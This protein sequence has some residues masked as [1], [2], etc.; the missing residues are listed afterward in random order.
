MF[1]CCKKKKSKIIPKQKSNSYS[2]FLNICINDWEANNKNL[3]NAKVAPRPP[4]PISTIE[5]Y[6]NFKKKVLIK[7]NE[8]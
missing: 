5:S 6:V 8:K 1:T 7:K 3:N 4:T 2:D